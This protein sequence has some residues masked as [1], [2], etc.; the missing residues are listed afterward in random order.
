VYGYFGTKIYVLAC[1]GKG[2]SEKEK[3]MKKFGGR[4]DGW[5]CSSFEHVRFLGV[6]IARSKR[7]P[8]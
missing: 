8:R 2:A 7:G 4:I 1:K 6:G 3:N 5:I